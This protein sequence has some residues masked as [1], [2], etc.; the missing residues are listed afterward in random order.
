MAIVDER[1]RERE[2]EPEEN[3]TNYNLEEF[4]A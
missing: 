3:M 4:K 1:E 2:R